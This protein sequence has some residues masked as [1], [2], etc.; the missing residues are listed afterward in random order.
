MRYLFRKITE[1]YISYKWIQNTDPFLKTNRLKLE[2]L[3][4]KHANRPCFIIGNGP[5][6]NTMNLNL[7]KDY[8]TIACNAFYLKHNE[9]NF[10]PTYYSVEDPL[11][12]YDNRNEIMSLEKTTKI[13]PYDL[14]HR[15]KPADDTVYINFLRSYILPWKKRFP[16][17]SDNAGKVVYWGGTVAYMNIQLAYYWGCNPIYLIGMDLN[18]KIPAD[19]KQKGIV[20]TSQNNDPNHFHPAYFGKGKKWHLPMVERMQKS[21][22][23]AHNF[24]K[25]RKISLINATNG[26]N[27]KGVPR[28]NYAD[29]F[30][31]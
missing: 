5:S 26:G 22:L 12:A 10:I 1:K 21:F 28:I 11:P 2:S 7:M 17:F 31:L 20:L 9:L 24:L 6:L 27:L 29:I 15:I 3:K 4:E 23:T 30:K 14:K 18:Y 25:E 13:I 8:I 19:I 16:Y